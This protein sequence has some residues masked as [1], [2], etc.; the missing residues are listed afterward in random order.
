VQSHAS[1]SA[2]L[3][4]GGAV[5][6][7]STVG[8]I[9]QAT[10]AAMSVSSLHPVGYSPLPVAH[11]GGTGQLSHVIPAAPTVQSVGTVAP[12][13]S[14]GGMGD[15]SHLTDGA[16]STPSVGMPQTSH[17]SAAPPSVHPLGIAQAT[18][19]P[20]P[21][22]ATSA[23]TPLSVAP[24][25]AI[26]SVSQSCTPS[27]PDAN[28]GSINLTSSKSSI[29]IGGDSSAVKLSSSVDDVSKSEC[30]AKLTEPTPSVKSSTGS[31][32]TD[33]QAKFLEFSQRKVASGSTGACDEPD[34]TGSGG[35]NKSKK[36]D[37]VPVSSPTV[38]KQS[39]SGEEPPAAESLHHTEPQQATAESSSGCDAPHNIPQIDGCFDCSTDGSIY[40]D[41]DDNECAAVN[42]NLNFDSLV[43][44]IV[45]DQSMFRVEHM[46][47]CVD[48]DTANGDCDEPELVQIWQRVSL[49]VDGAADEDAADSEKEGSKNAD[50]SSVTVQTNAASSTGTATIEVPSLS[51]STSVTG[52]EASLPGA[53]T[54][55]TPAPETNT[56]TP[57]SLSSAQGDQSHNNIDLGA[58]PDGALQSAALSELGTSDEPM[59]VEQSAA[60]HE[61]P[62]VE[63]AHVTQPQSLEFSGT[64][65]ILTSEHHTVSEQ[66][67]DTHAGNQS[68]QPST[69]LASHAMMST[70]SQE[71][72]EQLNVSEKLLAEP[73]VAVPQSLEESIT[74]SQEQM[75]VPHGSEPVQSTDLIA[76]VPGMEI[77]LPETSAISSEQVARSVSA[78][79][80]G[81][82]STITNSEAP[83]TH[84]EIPMEVVDA[85]TDLTD[86]LPAVSVMSDSSPLQMAVTDA[87]M[88]VE[89]QTSVAAPSV[90]QDALAAEIGTPLASAAPPASVDVAVTIPV[91]QAREGAYGE[92]G[93]VS[94]PAVVTAVTSVVSSTIVS[95]VSSVDMKPP[96]RPELMSPGQV[97][98]CRSHLPPQPSGGVGATGHMYFMTRHVVH[99]GMPGSEG[100]PFHPGQPP[101]GPPPPYPNKHYVG[102]PQQQQQQQQQQ[103]QQ[104]QQQQQFWPRQMHPSALHMGGQ[105]PPTEWM[106]HP[107]PGQG[108]GQQ[109][110]IRY[111]PMMQPGE[112]SGQPQSHQDWQYAMQ[113]PQVQPQQAEWVCSQSVQSVPGFTSQ[114]MTP[115]D[116]GHPVYQHVAQGVHTSSGV[117]TVMEGSAAGHQLPQLPTRPLPSPQQSSPASVR[118]EHHDLASP[119]SA[120]SRTPHNLSQ[121]GTPQ[122]PQ[123]GTSVT[124]GLGSDS[125]TGALPG[126]TSGTVSSD[127]PTS[128]VTADTSAQPLS[129]V[130]SV[131]SDPPG[132]PLVDNRTAA[133]FSA[134][135]SSEGHASYTLSGVPARPDMLQNHPAMMQRMYMSPPPGS[136]FVTPPHS[137]YMQGHQP[138]G[139]AIFRI[140][141]SSSANAHSAIGALLNQQRQ[142]M[143][144]VPVQYMP[145]SGP[146]VGD[147]R[148]QLLPQSSH[149]VYHSSPRP[150]FPGAV[151][152]QSGPV[153]APAGGVLA[154]PMHRS[155]APV[156]HGDPTV[157]QQTAQG[158]S[159]MPGSVQSQVS[160]HTPIRMQ[161]G[162]SQ[163]RMG[164]PPSSQM[165]MRPAS[166]AGGLQFAQQRMQPS[167]MMVM[168]P[169]SDVQQ[170]PQQ[171]MHQLPQSDQM[172]TA[173]FSDA[174]GH[175]R[176][177][178][179]GEQP[180]LLE[181]L[182]EQVCLLCHFCFCLYV[183][184]LLF[185]RLFWLQALNIMLVRLQA[186]W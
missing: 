56:V 5:N 106:R 68:P 76:S 6:V 169:N 94:G 66:Q 186:E 11:V 47:Q 59:K 60:L 22:P 28:S 156:M 64:S 172:M 23:P 84:L 97:P 140:P 142:P 8:T 50:S 160:P 167:Q 111:P 25:V 54:E 16:S 15:S 102:P 134:V 171:Q 165:M 89:S 3:L 124:P 135:S 112:W 82:M 45:F 145:R 108:G 4:P 113:T 164:G 21:L 26:S 79:V 115:A 133:A 32:A 74:A 33:F 123:S 53:V 95:A 117:Q 14:S 143:P 87:N 63:V 83:V 81:V 65:V 88:V 105:Q 10:S 175:Y 69:T 116:T 146:G 40:G 179:V 13:A 120:H 180:L 73:S 131:Q 126:A 182:L 9:S 130:T 163:M 121:P 18:H 42:N 77:P 138:G 184:S 29:T 92:S 101:Q 170:S 20:G 176:S 61:S 91:V 185:N 173:G 96:V 178:L 129:A 181:D 52:V 119:R 183:S 90:V 55:A 17:H 78:V 109:E 127:V 62:D 38:K 155:L 43:A 158:F 71:T 157:G 141:S 159:V 86:V 132:P 98:V 110:W 147:Q 75:E 100:M 27:V 48:D 122:M 149:E 103:H 139:T 31:V 153:S 24:T 151:M 19:Q 49:Q 152:I 37:P 114:N 39:P 107:H 125:S 58:K 104:Q 93:I 51:S 154:P 161:I 144:G 44:S 35:A 36:V 128:A 177:K 118:L 34:V 41:D 174:S 67:S 72:V 12:F 166:A 2:A 168:M 80:E 57:D 1:V 162:S 137:M 70:E 148:Y 7:S 136:R 46:L 85:Q 30:Q 150:G 99:Q